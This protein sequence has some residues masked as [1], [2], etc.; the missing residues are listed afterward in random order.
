MDKL[1]QKINRLI[2]SP[3]YSVKKPIPEDI[4]SE[5]DASVES[6]EKPKTNKKKVTSSDFNDDLNSEIG[7]ASDDESTIV[8]G[9]LETFPPPKSLAPKKT[10]ACNQ[11]ELARQLLLCSTSSESGGEDEEIEVAQEPTKP[12]VDK[13][14]TLKSSPL[15]SE[16]DVGML[17]TCCKH[18][19]NHSKLQCFN[20]VEN[21][22]NFW[23]GN[24]ITLYV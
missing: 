18:Y 14:A 1:G 11:N 21:I 13:A 10:S 2:K 7:L 15:P 23:F 17:K 6:C 16:L 4:V 12:I 9:A 19:F 5:S 3:L 8:D 20:W 24:T 22:W